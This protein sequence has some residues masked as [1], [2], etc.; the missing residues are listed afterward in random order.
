VG[1][2]EEKNIDF[3]HVEEGE[4]DGRCLRCGGLVKGM[5]GEKG[6]ALV[7]ADALTLAFSHG[8]RVQ[9]LKPATEVAV[10]H[11]ISRCACT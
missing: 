3:V 7:R 9:I 2:L 11:F 5:M 1:M 6:E 8:E 10:L 4:Y